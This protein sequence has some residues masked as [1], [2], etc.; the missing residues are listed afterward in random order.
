MTCQLSLLFT[1]TEHFDLVPYCQRL[2]IVQFTIP[3]RKSMNG[4]VPDMNYQYLGLVSI[5]RESITILPGFYLSDCGVVSI[6]HLKRARQVFL[7]SWH[8]SKSS[9]RW[10]VVPP[11]FPG[12]VNTFYSI[13]CRGEVLA[14]PSAARQ[15]SMCN[16]QLE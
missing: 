11:C 16:C 1:S 9:S 12:F 3:K 5:S 7:L 15:F 8:P 14:H 13:V 2:P 6:I 10:S 4:R